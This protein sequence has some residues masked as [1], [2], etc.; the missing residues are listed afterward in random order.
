MGYPSMLDKRAEHFL[1]D[2]IILDDIRE[3]MTKNILKDKNT[4]KILIKRCKWKSEKHLNDQ[5]IRDKIQKIPMIAL[6]FMN[7]N[8]K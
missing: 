7:S 1:I 8:I 4:R 5:E 2:L 3:V 6:A